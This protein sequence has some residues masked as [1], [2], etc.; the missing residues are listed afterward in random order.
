MGLRLPVDGIMGPETRSAIRDFQRREGL[1]VDGIVGPETK[2]ALIAA[3]KRL[4]SAAEE[5]ESF[6]TE[7]TQE[8]W[9]GEV[10]RRSPDYIR[11]VQQALNKVMGLRLAVD[12]IM[13][14]ATRS[15]IRSFQKRQGLIPDGIVGPKT[16]Q[17]LRLLAGG[18][19]PAATSKACQHQPVDC[20]PPGNPFEVLDKFAFAKATLDPRLHLPKI[21]NI[22]QHVIA[23]HRTGK[24]I[25]SILIAGHTDPVGSDDDNFALGWRRAQAVFQELCRTIDRMKPGLTGKIKFELTSCGERQQK[26]TSEFSRRVEVFLSTTGTAPRREDSSCG[27]PQRTVLAEIALELNTEDLEQEKSS[28]TVRPRLCLFQNST[29]TSHRNHF[30]C[31][32]SR[33]ARRIGAIAS[34]DPSNCRRRVG[35]TPYDTGADIIRAIEAAYQCLGERVLDV[36]HI[37]SHGF[38]PGVP[39]TTSGFAGLYQ[40]SFSLV[41]RS[42][43][44]RTVADVPTTPLANNVVFVLH[45]C[46]MAAGADNFARSLYEHL[47]R[48]LS[49]PKVY[50]HHNGG[51]A[52]RNNSWREYSNRHPT[53]RNLR[54]LPNLASARCC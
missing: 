14:P 23:S 39:G 17:Q 11:W 52:G 10:H 46:N 7:L 41:E 25:K 43:G 15:A 37:F 26:S 29:N 6:N 21:V 50:G 13:G 24:P 3:R 4:S 42:A 38:P 48:S 44:G 45:G 28:V 49:N 16:E 2:Q 22:A 51:C 18:L 8:V 53:G 40:D 31:G 34:P 33:Q 36:I 47:A 12:G 35:A 20:P 19:T 32:A 5:F 9:Q 54:S 1:P 27:V 30:Q